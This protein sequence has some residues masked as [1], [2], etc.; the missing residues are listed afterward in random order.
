MQKDDLV[1]FYLIILYF[2]FTKTT[3]KVL[4]IIIDFFKI[5]DFKIEYPLL[6]GTSF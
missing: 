6:D 4:I 3:E 2:E 1:I 5:N